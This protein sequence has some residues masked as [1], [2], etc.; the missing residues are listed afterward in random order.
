[1]AEHVPDVEQSRR[2][3][4]SQHLWNAHPDWFSHDRSGRLSTANTEDCEGVFLQPSNPAV[5]EHLFKVF[6][7]V[8]AR[9]DV[10]G[11]HFDYVRYPNSSYDFS[12]STLNRFREYMK[13][14]LPE[15]RAAQV[16]AHLKSDPK[17]YVHAYGGKWEEW[18]RAQVTGLVTRVSEAVKSNKPWMQ[19][20]AAVFATPETALYDR[21]QDW[22]TWLKNG[23]LDA[24]AL[25]AYSKDTA[26]IAQQTRFAVSIAGDRKVYTGIGA[27]RLQAHDVAQKIVQARRAGASGISLF[28]YDE[29]HAKSHYLDTLAR[30]VFASRSALPRMRWLPSRSGVVNRD[31]VKPDTSR[32]EPEK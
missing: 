24:V 26:R 3:R 9:Y 23:T 22:I 20:S 16:D 14:T 8:A 15:Q 13:T 29:V 19:V 1:M 30:S 6:T 27:W 12:G 18:R 25:M 31:A 4:S 5:Q 28:S 17:A 2:P 21:G 11:I 7:D 32:T 10:D